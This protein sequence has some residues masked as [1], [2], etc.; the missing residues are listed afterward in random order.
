MATAPTLDVTPFYD[1]KMLEID[2]ST[3]LRMGEIQAAKTLGVYQM[4]GQS[5]ATIGQT[6]AQIYESKN[7]TAVEMWKIG[8]DQ[9]RFDLEFG[10]RQEQ[11]AQERELR[12]LEINK[13]KWDTQ[14]AQDN[15][16][17][18]R[19]QEIGDRKLGPLIAM[20][21]KAMTEDV[22]KGFLGLEEIN[23]TE[24]MT[25]PHPVTGEPVPIM[26]GD[27]IQGKISGFYGPGGV[28]SQ[29]KLSDDYNPQGMSAE[30]AF[31]IIKSPSHP[32]RKE[33]L[34]LVAAHSSPAAFEQLA[35][36]M[37]V[38]PGS[39]DWMSVQEYMANPSAGIRD[40]ALQQAKI[41]YDQATTTKER[42]EAFQRMNDIETAVANDWQN[43]GRLSVS[44]QRDALMTAIGNDGV[45]YEEQIAR[46]DRGW[47]GDA[48]KATGS[49]LKAVGRWI[50]QKPDDS[51]QA[52]NWMALGEASVAEY[53]ARGNTE[54]YDR[55]EEALQ[56]LN[57][58]SKKN[59][60]PILDFRVFA[61]SF[62]TGYNPG[63]YPKWKKGETPMWNERMTELFRIRTSN[64]PVTSMAA[65]AQPGLS[66]SNPFSNQEAAIAAGLPPGTT[67][68]FMDATGKPMSAVTR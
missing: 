66:L 3:V 9:R 61:P 38:V 5:I 68:Y 43:A 35:S 11:A 4:M 45:S 30:R 67:V 48:M 46:I 23:A 17:R 29:R 58:I 56:R 63:G 55:A 2:A 40:R 60:G 20:T 1:A 22:A 21:S 28:L 57:A 10:L 34:R 44:E 18:S 51:E 24:Q 54:S 65:P 49:G 27:Y 19:A 31:Q 25:M 41:A 37:G 47:F 15:Y 64:Q 53:L 39:A 14:I 50:S 12:A 62:T 6:V 32:D 26:S 13:T 33:A 8:E 16:V 52:A 7:R 42:Q 36:R 59:G